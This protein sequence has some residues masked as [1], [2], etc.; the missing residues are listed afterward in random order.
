MIPKYESLLNDLDTWVKGTNGTLSDSHRKIASLVYSTLL[1]QLRTL[2]QVWG[3]PVIVNVGEYLKTV[4][5]RIAEYTEKETS[6]FVNEERKN[7]RDTFTSKMLQAMEFM[8]TTIFPE[9]DEI[10]NKLNEV[11]DDL[12]S[13]VDKLIA[14]ATKAEDDYKTLKR[15]AIKRMEVSN[16]LL[17]FKG[18]GILVSLVGGPEAAA[19]GEI[20]GQ[21]MSV[22][23]TLALGDDPEIRPPTSLPDSITNFAKVIEMRN[24]KALTNPRRFEEI[25]VLLTEAKKAVNENKELL[26]KSEILSTIDNLEK[27]YNQLLQRTEYSLLYNN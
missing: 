5:A 12:N 25:N 10:D 6:V 14:A 26:G 17:M 18:A 3:T 7:Y 8:N 1:N 11:T 23:Q 21:A 24:K 4:K 2:R 19:V 13:A 15:E 20:I 27:L 22:G 16:T 9:L